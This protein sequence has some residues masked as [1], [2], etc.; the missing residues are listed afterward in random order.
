[1]TLLVQPAT[2]ATE[3]CALV[4][5]IETGQTI[6]QS[7]EGTPFGW[8]FVRHHRGTQVEE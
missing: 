5:S 1:M 2:P 3:V 4:S 8:P 6:H 7:S